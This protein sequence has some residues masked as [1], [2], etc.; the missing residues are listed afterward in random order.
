MTTRCIHSRVVQ[1]SWISSLFVLC[2]R[3]SEKSTSETNR[4]AKN[5]KEF[6]PSLKKA[7]QSLLK[8][9]TYKRLITNSNL[10]LDTI[11]SRI[12]NFVE[13]DYFLSKIT[14][15]LDSNSV[16]LS[17]F[18]YVPNFNEIGYFVRKITV[19]LELQPIWAGPGNN[20]FQFFFADLLVWWGSFRKVVR[21]KKN[22]FCL[23]LDH[24]N[25]IV[26]V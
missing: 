7:L 8:F 3:F 15:I 14:V 11:N 1:F 13:I 23:S 19:I 17:A 25:Y 4:S 22:N 18:R 12:P 21:I 2:V 16:T 20:F 24:S 6:F 5:W 26:Y 10:T 9:E